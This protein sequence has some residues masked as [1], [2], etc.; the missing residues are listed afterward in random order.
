MAKRG[1]KKGWTIEGV[2]KSYYKSVEKCYCNYCGKE[3]YLKDAK[4][5]PDPRRVL[6][7]LR[8]CERCYNKVNNE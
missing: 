6:R 3:M 2:R 8:L 5:V 7:E 1:R 4:I